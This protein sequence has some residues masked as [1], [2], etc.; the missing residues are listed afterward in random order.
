MLMLFT[1]GSV[2][3]KS[4]IGYGAYL[5]C[6]DLDEDLE[7]LSG[8]IK[9]K[10]F[11]D[12]SS[13][14]LELQTLLWALSELS[15]IDIDVYTDSQ[16]I[17]RLGSRRERLEQNGYYS[18][19]GKRLKNHELYRDYFRMTDRLSIKLNHVRGHMPSR[20][21]NK[22]NRVFSLVDKA[23][24]KALRLSMSSKSPKT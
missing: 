13:S 4:R 3:S 10:C 24:R 21:K 17:L 19:S 11:S 18:S 22:I 23:S 2:S 15:V 16:N 1:D 14:R 6:T 7:V 8:T 9:T 20:K 5:V 12:T